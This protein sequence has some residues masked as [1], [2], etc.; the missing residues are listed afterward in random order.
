MK[1]YTYTIIF[2]LFNLAFIYTFINK[3]DQVISP[4]FLEGEELYSVYDLTYDD[5][6][7][8]NKYKEL[9]TGVNYNDYYIMGFV[10]DKKYE[11]KIANDILNI[12]ITG[13]NFLATIDEYMDKYADILYLYNMEDDID[14]IYKGEVRIKNIHIRCTKD[15]LL[16]L[17]KEE[18]Y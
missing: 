7:T 14:L 3:G 4:V 13:G 9:F 11:G 5:G 15:V 1:K 2:I 16:K 12:S 10:L 17:L 6:L 8:L 18:K